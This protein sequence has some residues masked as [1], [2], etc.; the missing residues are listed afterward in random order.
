MAVAP[1]ATGWREGSER[2]PLS[3]EIALRL[4][5][6]MRA[7]FHVHYVVLLAFEKNCCTRELM[8]QGST[9]TNYRIVYRPSKGRFKTN[10][11]LDL[12]LL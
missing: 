8:V 7:Q 10:N 12:G 3:V 2:E 5:F 6:E 4:V 1:D 11:I 9:I